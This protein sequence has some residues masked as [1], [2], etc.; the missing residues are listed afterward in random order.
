MADKIGAEM[1][2][3]ADLKRQFDT[4][5]GE[6]EALQRQLDGILNGSAGWWWGGAADRFR[7]DWS[8]THSPNIDRLKEALQGCSAE[9]QSRHE[10]LVAAGG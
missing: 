6:F 1:G 4:K 9:V 2:Q 8:S 10:S 7:T 3:L 5:F